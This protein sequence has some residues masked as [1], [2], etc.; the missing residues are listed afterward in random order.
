[1]LAL[2]MIAIVS[3]FLSETQAYTTITVVNN[4]LHRTLL[5]ARDGGILGSVLEI[6]GAISQGKTLDEA[7]EHLREALWLTLR[8]NR[9]R[10]RSQIRGL[11]Q[12]AKETIG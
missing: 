5:H 8:A 12:I 6:P 2:S 1:M 11:R 3:F 10:T 9:R 7:R 4:G